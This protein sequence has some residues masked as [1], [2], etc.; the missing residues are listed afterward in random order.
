MS[1][2]QVK[3]DRGEETRVAFLAPYFG[4]NPPHPECPGS[5]VLAQGLGVVTPPHRTAPRHV[6]RI[7]PLL[8]LASL[9]DEVK[10]VVRARLEAGHFGSVDE[11]VC[12]ALRLF[13]EREALFASHR[14]ELRA[15]IAEGVVAEERGELRDGGEAIAD[16][17]RRIDGRLRRGE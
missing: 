9:P 11:V 16:V 12:E 14:E 17:R 7:L 13:Q 8:D 6:A 4:R 1:A 5:L 10:E 3:R 15:R 2:R